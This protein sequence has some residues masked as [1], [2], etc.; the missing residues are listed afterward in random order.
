MPSKY[1]KHS[2]LSKI[3][4]AEARKNQK[5]FIIGRYGVTQEIYDDAIL[6]GLRWCRECKKFLPPHEF[7]GKDPR[8]IECGKARSKRWRDGRSA[9]HKTIDSEYLRGWRNKHP[10]SSSKY[11]FTKY[12]VDA[13]W[14]SKKKIEQ[15]SQCA[16]CRRDK[17]EKRDFCIDHNHDTHAV[18]GLLCDRCNIFIGMLEK[19]LLEKALAYLERYKQP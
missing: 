18:R 11:R 9:I 15:E 12:S 4:I 3:K 1:G 14:Y 13:E 19:G 10:E 2:L 5:S 8:C 17:P 7:Y 16:V 6:K